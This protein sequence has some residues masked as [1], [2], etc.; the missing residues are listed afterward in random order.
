[1][2]PSEQDRG[3][4]IVTLLPGLGLLLVLAGPALFLQERLLVSGKTVV[5]GVAIAIL[6]GVLLRNLVGLPEA[7]KPGVSLAVKRLLRIGVALRRAQLSLRQLLETGGAALLVA[8]VSFT[9]I[10]RLGIG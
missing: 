3:R 6:L 2:A 5:S 9:L 1:M 4:R 7:C 8:A 10:S